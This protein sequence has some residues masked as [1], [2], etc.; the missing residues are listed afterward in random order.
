MPTVTRVY[1]KKRGIEAYSQTRTP[2]IANSHV[3]LDVI[4]QLIWLA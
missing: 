1:F 4:T 2:V 3:A